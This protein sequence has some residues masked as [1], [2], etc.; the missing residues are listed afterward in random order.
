MIGELDEHLVVLGVVDHDFIDAIPLFP[1]LIED[2]APKKVVDL[3]TIV[4]AMEAVS[5]LQL[6]GV[7]IVGGKDDVP[8]AV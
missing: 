8:L 5:S 1:H 2:L 6:V 4:L 7:T 3:A